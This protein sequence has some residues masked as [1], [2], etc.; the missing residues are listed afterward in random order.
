MKRWKLG[1][2]LTFAMAL[3]VV[4]CGSS[5]TSSVV[6][7]ITPITASV[8]TNTTQQFSSNVTGST[9]TTVTWT[10]TCATGVTAPACGTINSTTGLY[11]APA[12]LPTVPGTN[13][14]LPVVTPTATITATSQADTTKIQTA[15]ITIITGIS[16]SITPVSATIGTGETF[17]NFTAT[18]NNPGCIIQN[19]PTCLNVTW[20]LPTVTT[21]GSDGTINP[22]TGVYTAPSTAPSPNSIIV[23][24]TS[25]ADTSVTASAVITIVTSIAPTVTS[26]SP[27]V[28]GLGGVFQ[29]TYITGTNFISTNNVFINAGNGGGNVPLPSLLVADVSSTLIRI[30]IPDYILASPPASGVLQ[31]SV[32]QQVGTPQTCTDITQCQIIV[33]NVRP[34]IAGLTPDSVSQSASGGP[35]FSVNGGFFGTGTNPA[36]S[37]SFNGQLRAITLPASGATNSARQMNV[38]IGGN[39]NSSDFATPG[40]YPVKVQNNQ[41]ASKFAVTNLTVKPNYSVSSLQTIVQKLPVGT[42]PSDIAINPAT[43]VAVVAN[44]GSNNVSLVDLTAPTPAVVATICT[45]A[46]GAIAPCPASGPISVAVDYVRNV[47]LVANSTTTPPSIAVIDLQGKKVSYVV[48][49]PPSTAVS[50]GSPAQADTP[51]A[52]GINPVTGRA[53]V[54]MQVKGYGLLMDVTQTPPAFVGPVTISTGPHTRIAVEPHLNWAVATPGGAGSVGIVDLNRQS[55]NTITNL[56]RSSILSSN[57]VTVT[58]AASTASSSVQQPPLTIKAGD[59]VLIQNASASD[60]SFDGIYTVSGIGPAANQFTYTQTGSPLPDVAGITSTGTINYSEPVATVG[61]TP[62]IQGIAINTQTQQ[63][64]MVDPSSSGVVTFFNLVD[65]SVNTLTLT[66]TT[67]SIN[68]SEPGAIA[69]AFNPLTNTIVTVNPNG[70]ILSVI[71]PDPF[72]PLRLVRSVLMQP[73]PVAVAIDPSTNMA[74]TANQTDNSVTV[75]SLGAI[76]SFSITETSPKT[77]VAS[78]TLTSPAAPSAVTLTVLGNGFLSTSHV[79]LDGVELATTFVSGRQL[80]AIVPPS[81]LSLAHRFVLDVQNSSGGITTNA[82]DFTVEQSVDVSGACAASPYPAGVAID[83][84]QNLVAVSLEGCNSLALISLAD[85]TGTTV[86]VG[87]NPVGVAVFPRL[88]LA[89]VANSGSPNASVVDELSQTVILSPATASGSIGVSADQDTGEAAVANSLANTVSIINVNTGGSSS[90]STG[91]S[92]VATAFNNQNHQ[93]AVAAAGSNTVGFGN[94][95]TS[96]LGASFSVS[97]PTSVVYDPVPSE[98]GP[99]NTVGCFLATSSTTN[100]VEIIDPIT[101][102]VSSFRV[103]INPTAIAYNYLTSTLVSTNTLSHTVTVSD[104]LAKTIRAVLTLPPSPPLLN[105]AA[106][107]L[108]QFALDIHPLTNLAII[109]DTSNGRVLFVPIPK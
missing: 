73:S 80:T 63:A 76:Q 78:S 40:L 84:L 67:N 1:S 60:P 89:V 65:Q 29:D 38:V 83:P 74:V 12:V 47:A 6:L 50:A 75:L 15:T 66:V 19:N 25:V 13:G 59:A 17:S 24:A 41:D 9:N 103:G 30:R 55:A 90:T 98:C 49:L 26:V 23:T 92:P 52:I 100:V 8:I 93:I 22:T 106:T 97:V 11:T 3:G 28:M 71:D 31:V 81:L 64:V 33:Q 77:Y 37:A 94:A 43:G 85:G 102:S 54:A 18:V 46:V 16:I 69:A 57:V 99:N 72:H 32:S 79:R 42:S 53:L 70:N 48:S 35:G 56:S 58:V 87:S 104:F 5:S 95:G 39:S 36:V 61:L 14:G 82:E 51:G 86:S 7:T 62:G 108:P 10:L 107:G 68:A 4:G 45:A 20:S 2:I 88:H 101:S 109:A 96:T 27:N 105:L 21:A 34:A 44:T 91:Q